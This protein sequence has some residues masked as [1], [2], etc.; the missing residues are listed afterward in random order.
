[1]GVYDNDL[2]MSWTPNEYKRKLKAA[3]LREIDEIERMTI[4]AMF[5]RYAN[6]AKKVKPSQMF[7]A[8]KARADLERDVTSNRFKNQ[9]DAKK[10][11]DLNIGLRNMLRKPTEEG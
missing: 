1:M 2:I 7:D 4:N 6:N 10:L 9:V 3:K 8:Q 5:H 11:N